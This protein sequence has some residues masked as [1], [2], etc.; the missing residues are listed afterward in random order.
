MKR[1]IRRLG[2]QG[3]FQF[4]VHRCSNLVLAMLLPTFSATPSQLHA[5]PALQSFC[6][7]AFANSEVVIKKPSRFLTRPPSFIGK[8]VAFN[9]FM[10]CFVEITTGQL[11]PSYQ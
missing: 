1:R 3:K 10:L 7:A 11:P 8:S 9:R 2:N 4:G 5:L 6:P